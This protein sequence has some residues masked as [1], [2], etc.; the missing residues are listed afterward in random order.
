MVLK[1][2]FF[3]GSPKIPTSARTRRGRAGASVVGIVAFTLLGGCAR[4]PD[5]RIAQA[6]ALARHP[7]ERNVARIESLLR[8]PD[9]DVRATSLVVMETLDHERAKRMAATAVQ[10]PDGL[11]RIAAITTLTQGAD[12]ATLSGLVPLA[13]QDPAW[14]VRTRV[15]DALA[16]SDD[17]QVRDVFAR[18]LSDSVRH[19]RRAALRAGVEHPGLLPLDRVAE[20]LASDPDWEN[21]VEAARALG[22][23]KDPSAAAALDAGAAD[24]NEFVRAAAV[25]ERRGIP[26]EA[27]IPN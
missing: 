12:P 20:L 15:L 1:A 13:A 7:S 26:A 11:V 22:A 23:S 6:Y 27:A 17:P 14:Q 8:D 16:G 19:V 2:V 25:R 3:D 4:D 10:D 5:D 21:R 18:A 24:P 9:R